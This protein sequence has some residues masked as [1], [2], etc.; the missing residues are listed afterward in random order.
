MSKSIRIAFV[1]AVALAASPALAGEGHDHPAP[2][3]K[4]AAQKGEKCEHGVE[5]A[6]C[7]R[8]NPKL[9]AVYKAKGDWC[10]EHER[11]ES[12]CVPCH[13]ELAKKGVK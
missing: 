9:A 8:C 4:P 12:Q 5:K 13:P 7:A 6:V 1:A 11:P 10:A 2:A 3:Q